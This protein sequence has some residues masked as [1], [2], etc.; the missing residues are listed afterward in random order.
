MP[1]RDAYVAVPNRGA[2]LTGTELEELA[3]EA[4]RHPDI[5][6]VARRRSNVTFRATPGAVE[7]LREALGNRVIIEADRPMHPL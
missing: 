7:E 2:Q 4:E 3:H 5:E 1:N 6:A